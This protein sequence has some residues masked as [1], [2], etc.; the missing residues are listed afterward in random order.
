MHAIFSKM[1]QP[2]RATVQYVLETL[3]A[4]IRIYAHW[5]EERS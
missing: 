4:K 1:L 2:P 3:V 5:R